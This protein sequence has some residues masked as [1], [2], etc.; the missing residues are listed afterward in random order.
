MYWLAYTQQHSDILYPIHVSLDYIGLCYYCSSDPYLPGFE[1]H[2]RAFIISVS[3][4]EAMAHVGSLPHMGLHY[5][6][7][8]HL[9]LG[10]VDVARSGAEQFLSQSE[11]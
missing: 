1:N 7:L 4:A 6:P 9:R 10:F 3:R 8:M 2:K 11:I 5:G